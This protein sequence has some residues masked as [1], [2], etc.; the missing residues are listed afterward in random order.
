MAGTGDV[1]TRIERFPGVHYAVL[2]PNQKGL[3][4]ALALISSY[5]AT[6]HPPN[7]PPLTDEISIFA[8]ATD[9][10]TQAN[11][12][13]TVAES[14]VRF[15]PVAKNALANGLRVRGYVSV[16]IACPYTGQVDYRRVRDVAKELVEMGCYEISLGDT[17]GMGTPAQV[18]EMVEE[19]KKAVPVQKLAVSLF[20]TVAQ[21]GISLA[22]DF[23]V[24]S[25]LFYPTPFN[26]TCM[27]TS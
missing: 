16:A 18:S 10:F 20:F 13:T 8:A 5:A 23:I 24:G 9:A 14:L 3:D 19:V 25:C 15:A 17:V 11:L 21:L 1:I 26:P 6:S 22:H 4:N 27:L 12:N 7:V 2:V